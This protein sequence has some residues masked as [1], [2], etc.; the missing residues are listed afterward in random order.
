[1]SKS[2]CCGNMRVCLQMLRTQINASPILQVSVFSTFLPGTLRP[3]SL[4][5]T[6][7]GGR[8]REIEKESYRDRV[9]LKVEG[10]D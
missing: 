3:V 9:S 8:E 5:Y 10:K 1:M 4:V 6:V 7:A 2:N